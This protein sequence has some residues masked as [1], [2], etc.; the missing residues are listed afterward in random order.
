[1]LKHLKI[2]N[3]ALIN[4]IDIIFDEGL[5]IITGETGAGKSIILG[6]LGILL[7][8]RAD[9]RVISNPEY[10]T[11]V[12]GWF[13]VEG[14]MLVKQ[15]CEANDIEQ[16][17]SPL[18]IRRELSAGG[19]SRAF[20]NDSPTTLAKVQELGV[21]LID[22]HSQHQNQLLAQPLFQLS[23][24]DSLASNSALLADYQE[25]FNHYRRDL[26][27]YR[28]TKE[29]IDADRA[30]A[31]FL[32]YQLNKL[33]KLSPEPGELQN[34]EDTLAEVESSADTRANALDA[35]SLLTSGEPNILEM[36]S[37]V[38]D[39]CADMTDVLPADD[40]IDT[41]I[42]NCITELE[43]IAETIQSVAGDFAAD[44]SEIEYL[45]KRVR[46]I[47]DA[48]S[49]A[50]VTDEAELITYYADLQKKMSRLEEA[51]SLLAELEK[52][53][54]ASRAKAVEAAAL[55]TQSRRKAASEFAALLQTTLIPLGMKNLR[56][57]INV[58]PAKL[59]LTGADSVNFLFAFNKNQEPTPAAN[60]ASGGEISRVML[61]IKSIV[62]GKI[63]LPTVIF[64]EIDTGVSG[65]V[66]ARIG[67]MLQA[68]GQ[69]LQVIAITHLP[70]VAAMGNSHFKVYKED[71]NNSTHTHITVLSDAE[72]IDEIALMLSGNAAEPAARANA[73]AL[74]AHNPSYNS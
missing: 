51:P 69:N 38:S 65:D 24:I 63:S 62:A 25:C 12:E 36:L 53:A 55:L 70:Q 71:D 41:R 66:A 22:I 61:A 44:E 54:R 10:K 59:S 4:H 14:N 16:V 11:I 32:E 20:I 72:R 5:N 57:E 46:A 6:A 7:G 37:R 29:A 73:M 3:Y 19:R 8:G 58:E 30:N 42:Q 47:R 13:E 1:M 45:R 21:L 64:D 49:K 28:K 43:D 26:R 2:T 39:R 9:Q 68:M 52:K 60:A 48:I 31:D 23:V 35:V 74:L 33:D 50:G 67:V 17:F 18:I 15:F 34:C 56:V 27:A 40:K